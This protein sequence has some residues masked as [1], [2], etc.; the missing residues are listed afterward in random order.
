M[1]ERPDPL[2]PPEGYGSR[3]PASLRDTAGK[4]EPGWLEGDFLDACITQDGLCSEGRKSPDSP[5][6]CREE[7]TQIWAMGDAAEHVVRI[8]LCDRHGGEAARR[9]M[10]GQAIRCTSCGGQMRLESITTPDGTPLQKPEPPGAGF[11][12]RELDRLFDE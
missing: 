3:L 8:D 9:L 7:R 10:A 11:V 2:A 5:P 4:H 12:Q 6:A 1:T